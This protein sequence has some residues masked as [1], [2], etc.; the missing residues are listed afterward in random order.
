MTP[1]KKIKRAWRKQGRADG[2]PLKHFAR[3]HAKTGIDAEL[4]PIAQAWL[5]NKRST[6]A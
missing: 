2:T 6:T 3:A 5:K 4:A 1:G